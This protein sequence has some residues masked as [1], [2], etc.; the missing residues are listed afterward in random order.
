[1][2]Y[3]TRQ[4]TEVLELLRKSTHALCAGDI[5]RQLPD[6]GSSSIYRI[7]SSLEEES[8]VSSFVRNRRRFY[9]YTGSCSH[10]LHASCSS[11]GT[12]IHLDEEASR[13]ITALL[14]S[15]ELSI[16]EDCMISIICPQCM[17][18]EER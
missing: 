14:A 6:V 15:R 5:I 16:N 3:N 11:C 8:L 9:S 10:H 12:L 7:L 4:K 17:K 13:A 1:M 18:K 2:N